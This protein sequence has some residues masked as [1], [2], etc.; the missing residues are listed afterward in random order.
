MMKKIYL[1]L[2][3]ALGA[4]V[5]PWFLPWLY[6]IVFPVKADDPFLAYSPVCDSFIVS[7][8]LGDGKTEIYSVDKEGRRLATFS[9]EER[10]SLLPQIYFN[11]LAGRE[12][13]PDSIGGVEL[14]LPALK[15]GQWVFSSLPR[16]I[17]KVKPE[18]F[19]IMESMPE[20]FDLEDP[21][22]VFTL[23]GCVEFRRIADGKIDASRSRRFDEVFRRCGFEYPARSL[24]ANITTR[25]PYDE[26]YLIADASGK[27]FHMKMQAGRPYMSEVR[28]LIPWKL[29][30]SLLWR[31]LIHASSDL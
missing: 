9:K 20:R 17:N 29:Q 21:D 1:T 31:I 12:A 19:L 3:V 28:L 15:H 11:Q 30:M 2:L 18:V 8:N 26:G 13:L 10:D 24:S 23:D 4:F 25:K 7:E 27:V 6:S 16:D 22:A 5:L 14:S